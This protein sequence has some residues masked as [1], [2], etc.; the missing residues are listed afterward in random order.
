MA[1]YLAFADMINNI[2]DWG[3][4]DQCLR[5]KL[6]FHAFQSYPRDGDVAIYD[7]Q[8]E[9][10]GGGRIKVEWQTTPASDTQ[11][12]YGPTTAYG[13]S[14]QLDPTPTTDHEAV[15]E[16][17]TPSTI[18]YFKVKSGGYENGGYRVLVPG[19]SLYNPDYEF[20]WR[21]GLPEGWTVDGKSRRLDSAEVGWID[22]QYSGSHAL[23]MC[24]ATSW[25][26]TLD[27]VAHQKVDIGMNRGYEFSSWLWNHPDNA[28]PY[29]LVGTDPTGGTDVNSPNVVWSSA[30]T[31]KDYW[32]QRSVSAIAGNSVVTLFVWG[33]TLVNDGA[34]HYFC[35]DD[36]ALTV[37]SALGNVKDLPDGASVTV[38]G[39]VNA[40]SDQFTD[41]CYIQEGST[42]TGLRIDKSG[43][44]CNLDDL[45]TVSGVLGTV[46]GER[47]LSATSFTVTGPGTAVK[48]TGM[49]NDDFLLDHAPDHS[50]A[51][52]RLWGEVTSVDG[53]A[54]S[55]VISDGAA[56]EGVK[57]V[58]SQVT[59][60]NPITPPALG[61]YVAVTGISS[62]T[63]DGGSILP[64]LKARSQADIDVLN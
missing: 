9:E 35:T 32:T 23:M 61:S 51:L 2:G 64:I 31:G 25:G 36:T 39:V 22:Q 45:A 34:M 47:R 11:V 19:P 46:D 20:G 63:D 33:R 28:S 16:G 40:S 42:P 17:L 4:T 21:A 6:G 10:L 59:A 14:T 8:L 54:E 38:I 7:V 5:P 1:S 57:V 55:F 3:F 56:A 49:S 53:A 52:V 60:G 48:P 62:A 50:G 29:A 15:V 24:L 12:F 44:F 27:D 26:Y 41:H 30:F 18:C 37:Y 13:F 43:D 58:Y